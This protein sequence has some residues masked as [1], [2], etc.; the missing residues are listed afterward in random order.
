MGDA[1]TNPFTPGAGI[2]PPYRAGREE[3]ARVLAGEVDSIAANRRGGIVVLYGPRGNGKTVQLG[4]AISRA[5]KSGARV[6]D[7]ST[8]ALGGPVS[9]AR[10]LLPRRRFGLR[11]IKTLIAGF[12]GVSVGAEMRDLPESE[13]ERLRERMRNH[14]LLLAVDEAHDMHP[15]TGK[16]LLQFAQKC[17]TERCPFLLLLAGTPGLLPHLE[18]T[19][20]TFWERSVLLRLGRL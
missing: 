4:E 8:V 19:G 10:S 3:I 20:A 18:K 15:R 2:A 11:G 1:Q 17:V 12:A 16:F 5:R 13:E 7:P 9:V 6:V 14:P